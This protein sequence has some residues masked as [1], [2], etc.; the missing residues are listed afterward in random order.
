MRESIEAT[1]RNHLAVGAPPTWVLSNHDVIR[2]AT[3][4]APTPDGSPV[5]TPMM[6]DAERGLRRAKA[7]T[8]FLLGLPGSAYVYQGEEL[9]LPEVFD[10]PNDA[11]QDPVW[12]RSNG[13]DIGRDGCRVPI[14]WKSQAPSF[15]FGPTNESWLPLPDSW[16]EYAVDRQQVDEAST[17]ALYRRALARRRAEDALGQGPM[18]WMDDSPEG[19][20]AIRRFTSEPD[21]PAVLV[22]INMSDDVA[23]MPAA[24]GD[25]VVL[26]SSDDVARVSVEDSSHIV[27]GPETAVWLRG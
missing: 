22:V 19:V 15:G 20:L 3:R 13:A 18:E 9:G 8:V 17:L 25:V 21:H 5:T 4:L 1:V 12:I 11:R 26:A 16:G 23:H 7:A 2:H 27:V 10:L 14:P 24:W 6:V